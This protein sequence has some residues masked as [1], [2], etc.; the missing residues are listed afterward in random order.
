M[1]VLSLECHDFGIMGMTEPGL[2][3]IDVLLLVELALKHVQKNQQ[4][5]LR[6]ENYRPVRNHDKCYRM[7]VNVLLKLPVGSWS[8]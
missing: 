6:G 4:V 7:P 1:I 2:I 3:K 5:P 8:K